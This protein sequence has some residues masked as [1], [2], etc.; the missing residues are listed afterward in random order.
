M[1][2]GFKLRNANGEITISDSQFNPEYVGL[3]TFQPPAGYYYHNYNNGATEFISATGVKVTSGLTGQQWV[4]YAVAK[5]QITYATDRG[6]PIPFIVQNSKV[7]H[8]A[9]LCYFRELSV[10]GSNTTWEIVLNIASEGSNDASGVPDVMVFSK[11]PASDTPAGSGLVVRDS[12]SRVAFN[13]NRKHLL[14]ASVLSYTSPTCNLQDINPTSS[15]QYICVYSPSSQ[16]IPVVPA[17]AA[18]FY[19]ND[20]SDLA[21]YDNYITNTYMVS[22]LIGRINGSNFE[23]TVAVNSRSFV[24]N[25]PYAMPRGNEPVIIIDASKYL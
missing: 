19:K 14:P 9:S 16:P 12:S 1:S 4:V 6:E 10:S 15:N 2:Y 21:F 23:S 7:N 18:F 3:A 24:R 11:Y 17:N 22:A 20:L 25:T 13:S 8:G 5:Y